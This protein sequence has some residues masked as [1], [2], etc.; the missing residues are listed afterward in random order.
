MDGDRWELRERDY[1]WGRVGALDAE[2]S[3][4]DTKRGRDR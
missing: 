4:E 1:G 3:R 2:Y